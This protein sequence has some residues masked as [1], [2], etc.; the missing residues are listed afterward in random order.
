[1]ENMFKEVAEMF[2]NYLQGKISRNQ[3]LTTVNQMNLFLFM[4]ILKM[5]NCY[6]MRKS[7]LIAKERFCG[8][9]ALIQQSLVLS[10]SELASQLT[11]IALSLWLYRFDKWGTVSNLSRNHSMS[12]KEVKKSE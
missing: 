12:A 1:M 8:P 7:S 2:V 5:A 10:G 6:D 3:A 11:H 4:Y 9:E